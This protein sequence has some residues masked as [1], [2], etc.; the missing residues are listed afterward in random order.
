V[1]EFLAEYGLFLAKAVTVLGV[2][3][4]VIGALFS[5]KQKLEQSGSIKTQHI[6]K[7]LKLMKDQINDVLLTDEQHKQVAK[8][9]KKA[10]KDKKKLEKKKAKKAK[11]SKNL[12]TEDED[13]SSRL[14][15]LDF[16]GDKEGSEVESL[17]REVTALLS[18]A[19]K[20]DQ[21]F[22]RVESPGGMVHTY[23]LAAAQLERIKGAG[24]HLTISVDKVA[25]S[26]GY[27]MACI[28]D[29]LIA[30]PF[31]IVGSIGVLVEITN[32]NRLLKKHDIDV[33]M[34]TAGE[35][36]HTISMLGEITPEAREK[37]ILELAAV[38]EMFKNFV[39]KYRPQLDISK[40]AT[41]E[42]WHGS[43]AIEL[44]M[45]DELITSDE[46]LCK[47]C[48]EEIDVFEISFKQKETI[49]DRL[50]IS[51][52]TTIDRVSQALLKQ[53]NKRVI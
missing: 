27:L 52:S 21:V 47:K 13:D 39:S 3:L 33:E 50:G 38:H 41:G 43:Q 1:L 46:Y 6:N 28:A 17:R 25:A 51:L 19:N 18:V 34:L 31:A 23:G 11:N 48:D 26:G 4:V 40:V 5:S 29:K 30:A 49:G 10:E 42:Y 45:V 22:V 12:K 24:L 14:F 16:D 44:Q 35:Y 20:N 9:E 53:L 36:K 37:T 7:V 15:V 8:A 2:I 32:F